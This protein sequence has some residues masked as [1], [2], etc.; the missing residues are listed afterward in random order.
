MYGRGHQ[1][2]SNIY[3]IDFASDVLFRSFCTKEFPCVAFDSVHI[4]LSLA[5]QRQKVVEW[6]SFIYSLPRSH[7]SYYRSSVFY[8]TN[9][10]KHD[11]KSNRGLHK[12]VKIYW[13]VIHHRHA[14]LL[15]STAVQWFRLREEFQ[16]CERNLFM[17]YC[18]QIFHMLDSSPSS[19]LSIYMHSLPP[20]LQ[21]VSSS[22]YYVAFDCAASVF[23]SLPFYRHSLDVGTSKWMYIICVLLFNK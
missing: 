18:Q 1:N 13:L 19:T 8:Q 10:R 3:Q 23:G 17:I 7:S 2:C 16:T 6:F 9:R 20:R 21:L 14:R 11:A 12:M 4:H 22:R 15:R 5:S